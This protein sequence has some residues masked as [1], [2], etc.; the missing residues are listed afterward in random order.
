MHQTFDETFEC[1]SEDCPMC[2]G[3]GCS[4]CGAGYFGYERCEHDVIERHL[5]DGSI[6]R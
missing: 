6:E 4:T 5:N 1:P 2:T 3:D